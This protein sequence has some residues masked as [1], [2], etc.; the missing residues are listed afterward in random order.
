MCAG[1]LTASGRAALRDGEGVSYP[2]RFPKARHSRIELVFVTA[3]LRH[4]VT[5][6]DVDLP[7]ALRPA[8]LDLYLPARR[9][10]R[11]GSGAGRLR[12][13]TG[14]ARPGADRGARLETPVDAGDA[15]PRGP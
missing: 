8:I 11:T 13:R 5:R 10:R 6:Q 3:P 9:F 2:R 14:A 1:Q 4:C 15:R 7:P 12:V